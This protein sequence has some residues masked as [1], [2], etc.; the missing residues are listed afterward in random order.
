M[1]KSTKARM[2]MAALVALLAAGLL[3][4]VWWLFVELAPRNV[5]TCPT[6]VVNVYVSACGCDRGK[7]PVQPRV[8]RRGSQP[9]R[10][11]LPEPEPPV[12]PCPP[13]SPQTPQ[14][15]VEPQPKDSTSRTIPTPTPT[16]I[17]TPVVPGRIRTVNTVG[18]VPELGSLSALAIGLIL[19]TWLNQ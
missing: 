8:A 5:A 6:P 13:F 2:I 11:F 4:L 10:T 12:V 16:P 1:D 19:T 18:S 15:S 9:K 3:L 17:P 7:T 14:P